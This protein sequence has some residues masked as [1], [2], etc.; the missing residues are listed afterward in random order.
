V[1]VRKCNDL[2]TI[3]FKG[4]W[5]TEDGTRVYPLTV[6]DAFSRFV[7]AVVLLEDQRMESV[8]AV[9]LELFRR[10]GI[11]LAMLSDNG[12]PFGCTGARAGFTRL[13]AWLVSLGVRV[14]FSRPGKPQ[15]NGAHERVHLD[16]RYDI[17]D[18]AST[19][20][21]EERDAAAKWLHKFN[22]HR[23][24]EA[25]GQQT[26]AEVYRPSVRRLLG[27]TRLPVYPPEWRVRTV[28]NP[29]RICVDGNRYHVGAGLIGHLVG[30]QPIEGPRV[31]LWFFDYDLGELDLSI[32]TQK[33]ATPVPV[34]QWMEMA[35]A[36]K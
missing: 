9:L 26:P 20:L 10:Y 28:T 17:E 4:W 33:R 11:P 35:E 23:P 1:S 8:R 21:A 30:L 18:N 5:T 22:Y 34:D 7:L 16:I 13:S 29:G 3:D 27:A 2:W 25:I 31:R 24:H 19:T 32:V 6:R 15:D 12:S 14:V 36:A